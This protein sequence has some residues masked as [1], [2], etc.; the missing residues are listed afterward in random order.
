MIR[1]SKDSC[2]NAEGAHI[3]SMK[4]RVTLVES[5]E[6]FAV[7]CDDLPG[8]CSQGA[9]RE[10][11]LE[12]IR[13]AIHEYIEAQGEIQTRFGGKITHETVTV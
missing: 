9:T 7:W 13:V 1:R 4:H 6:G 12:N 11:A 10:E 3:C 8:C 2:G 5:E